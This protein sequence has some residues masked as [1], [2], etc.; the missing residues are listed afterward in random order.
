MS[1]VTVGYHAAL[2]L[3]NQVGIERQKEDPE[4][5]RM[6]MVPRWKEME[7]FGM[8][9]CPECPAIVVSERGKALHIPLKPGR[10]VLVTIIAPR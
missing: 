3:M 9:D 4:T 2:L 8:S 7:V 5:Q 6:A 10:L 1:V